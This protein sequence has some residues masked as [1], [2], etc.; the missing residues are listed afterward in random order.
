[1]S[2]ADAA[3]GLAGFRHHTVSVDSVSPRLWALLL[4]A[5]P[6]PS[7]ARHGCT[8]A[9]PHVLPVH[10]HWE[11]AGPR[12]SLCDPRTHSALSK[13]VRR[14]PKANHGGQQNLG[15]SL[16]LTPASGPGSRVPPSSPSELHR[17]SREEMAA[18]RGTEKGEWKAVKI[19]I[20]TSRKPGSLG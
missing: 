8:S 7:G 20:P 19:T 5:C 13:W 4:A 16:V 9:P 1:M 11:G 6:S 17:L 12:S 2:R 3:V 14:A 10:I 18:P 15:C